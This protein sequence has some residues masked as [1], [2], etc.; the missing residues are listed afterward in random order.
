MMSSIN[1]PASSVWVF[2][3]QLVEHC[4]ANAEATGSNLVEA[5][6]NF[7]PGYFAIAKIAIQLRWSQSIEIWQY[8]ARV[9]RLT[10]VDSQKVKL[11]HLMDV[12]AVLSVVT[13]RSSPQT[14]ASV[15]T[16]CLGMVEPITAALI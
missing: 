15:R 12:A 8:C 16:A 11:H 2:I 10:A 6:K 5:P 13:Q 4:S 1:L 14:A 7:Y 3:A 9:L